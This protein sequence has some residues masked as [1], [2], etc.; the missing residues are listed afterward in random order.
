M[1]TVKRT[2][3]QK[4]TESGHTDTYTFDVTFTIE[5]TPTQYIYKYTSLTVTRTKTYS[6]SVRVGFIRWSDEKGGYITFPTNSKSQTVSNPNGW[7]STTVNKTH[8]SQSVSLQ[9][10]ALIAHSTTD[11][12]WYSKTF[13]MTVPAKTTYTIS[14]DG[15]SGT[16]TPSSQIKW[17]GETLTITSQKPTKD[18]YVFIGWAESIE[19]ASSG[20]VDYPA[21]ASYSDD[22][23][24]TLYAVWELAYTKPSINS[25]SVER[26]LQDGTSDDEGK[27]AEVTIAYSTYQSN[28]ARF[29]G[30]DTYPYAN[31][32]ASAE[33]QIGSHSVT[34]TSVSASGIITEIIGNDDFDT[35]IQYSVEVVLSDT[36]T[37][38]SD[39]SVTVT[40]MLSMSFFPMDFNADGT[41]LGIFRP[42]PD[43]KNGVFLGKDLYVSGNVYVQGWAGVVQ[44]YAGSTA[45]SGWLFC[46]G[47]EVA[48]DDYPLLYSVI[49]NTY[50]T[51]S[52][53]DH[54]VLPDLQS[55]FPIGADTS[56]PLGD[57]GGS[58]DAIVPYHSHSVSAVANAITGGS[59]H[60]STYRKKNAGS[61]SAIYVPDGGSTAN[62]IATT[63]NTHT[64][65]L[66][67]HNT[68]SVGTSGE[69]VGANIPPYIGIN[70]IIC[71]GETS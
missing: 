30:G 31:N 46:D 54:F 52:D 61:G 42:A 37:I 60:H 36:E 32:G 49:G 2:F 23:G 56:Y 3:T 63:D 8:S 64:H 38:Q 20:D 5:E 12:S 68:N 22:V 55:R 26:C 28:N 35:D 25:F 24:A 43:N 58:A 40:G 65:N 53:S 44:M 4:H 29:Y 33:I 71:T 13:T 50:G 67:A 27:Y 18:G 69:E 21:G 59:H 39:K 45:P 14:F 47:S 41:A 51:P 62:G 7:F 34:A 66:P 9:M 6:G 57:T 48:V 10:A 17:H 15:N 70:F 1:A 11:Y 19:G 16:D